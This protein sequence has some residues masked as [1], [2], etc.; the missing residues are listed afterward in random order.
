MKS[1]KSFNNSFEDKAVSFRVNYQTINDK[2]FN[3][4]KFQEE[5]EEEKKKLS[6]ISNEEDK[7]KLSG[8]TSKK[9]DKDSKIEKGSKIS[10]KRSQP[11][12][13][14]YKLQ[15]PSPKI[16]VEQ[17]NTINTKEDDAKRSMIT[18]YYSG[19]KSVSQMHRSVNE[20][21]FWTKEQIQNLWER[22][23]IASEKIKNKIVTDFQNI[24]NAVRDGDEEY[25]I[26]RLHNEEFKGFYRIE[27]SKNKLLE[28][29]LMQNQPKILLRVLEDNFYSFNKLFVFEFLRKLLSLD[30][31]EVK[32][33]PSMREIKGLELEDHEEMNIDGIHDE[34]LK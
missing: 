22:L 17:S 5:I 21:V 16:V 3:S 13:Q 26:E 8:R 12:K 30:S 9:S 18:S 4:E 33:P 2:V 1:S 19:R 32:N 15:Q 31:K 23:K 25:V 34:Q 6:I 24:Y 14:S 28:F 27:L 29:M 20:R 7:S 10:V 11:H